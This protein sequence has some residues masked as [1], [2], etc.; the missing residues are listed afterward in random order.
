MKN[1]HP[2][3][4][5]LSLRDLEVTIKRGDSRFV[6]FHVYQSKWGYPLANTVQSDNWDK[7]MNDIYHIKQI[8][9]DKDLGIISLL[10]E[11]YIVNCNP[12]KKGSSLK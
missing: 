2:L 4:G 1:K 12:I 3:A 5:Y 8:L 6:R 7:D 11:G 10:H 9:L